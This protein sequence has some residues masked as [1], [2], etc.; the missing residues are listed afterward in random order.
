MNEAVDRRRFLLATAGASALAGCSSSPAGESPSSPDASSSNETDGHP[1]AAATA[2]LEGIS[3]ALQYVRPATD[4]RRPE[5]LATEG[6]QYVVVTVGEST[7]EARDVALRLDGTEYASS[8]TAAADGRL[9]H[10][11]RAVHRPVHGRDIRLEI[12]LHPPTNPFVRLR[13]RR[14]PVT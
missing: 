7:V 4:S 8:F 10:R 6:R 11:I 2:D 12:V 9:R 1:D 13:L 5:V 14:R 3:A